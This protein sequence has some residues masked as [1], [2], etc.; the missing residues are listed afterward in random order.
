MKKPTGFMSNAPRLL[1]SLM[2]RCQGRGGQ[3]SRPSGGQHVT[4]SGRVAQDAARYPAGLCRAIIHGMVNEMKNRGIHR[5]GEVGLHAVN[6]EDVDPDHDERFSGA[7]RDDMSGQLLRDDLV[8]E[9]RQK[10]LKYFCE[11]GVWV[12]RPKDEARRRTGKGAISVRWVGVNKGDDMNPTLP[13]SSG[14]SPDE[15]PR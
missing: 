5:P 10:E 8:H 11:K 3:C 1:E 15:S 6:D 9:A 4:A 12:K 13:V 2:R 14:S 7:Y